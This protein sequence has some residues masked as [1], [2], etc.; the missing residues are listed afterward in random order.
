MPGERRSGARLTVGQVLEGAGALSRG[1]RGR[2]GARRGACAGSRRRWRGSRRSG[3]PGRSNRPAAAATRSATTPSRIAAASIASRAPESR[4]IT[5]AGRLQ[6]RG[7]PTVRRPARRTPRSRGPR[8]QAAV[9]AAPGRRRGGGVAQARARYRCGPGRS[10]DIDLREFAQ[11]TAPTRT[12]ANLRKSQRRN[13]GC[14]LRTD[15]AATRCGI[16]RT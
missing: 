6:Q 15:D 5:A 4:S 10:D 13:R 7:G 11:V 8:L 3:V 1:S 2:R 14:R 12:C 16:D 9:P